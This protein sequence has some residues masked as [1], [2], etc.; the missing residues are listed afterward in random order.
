MNFNSPQF[1]TVVEQALLLATGNAKWEKAIQRA[2]DGL[3][4]G[5]IVV[6]ELASG[7][8]V[9]TENG[10][11]KVAGECQCTAFTHGHRQCKHRAARRLCALFS[12]A[13]IS[14]KS[15]IARIESE[16]ETAIE[17]DRTGVSYKVTR[18]NGWSI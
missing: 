5:K 18:C 6:S 14:E 10:T 1:N 12:E 16:I 7:A 8:I 17:Y 2:A 9:T 11:Y 3:K 4:S 15:E 13:E